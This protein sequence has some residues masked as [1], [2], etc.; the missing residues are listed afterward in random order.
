[1]E[2]TKKEEGMVRAIK[3]FLGLCNHEWEDV[4]QGKIDFPWGDIFFR[5][6]KLVFIFQCKKCKK[7]KTRVIKY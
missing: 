1:V 6:I 4:S 2:N 5:H 7:I 3:H